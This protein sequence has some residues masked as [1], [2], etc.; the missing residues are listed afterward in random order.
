MP[1]TCSRVNVS[2]ATR[3][4]RSTPVTGLSSPT[5]PTVPAWSRA[6]PAN[7]HKY[8]SAVATSVVNAK[9]AVSFASRA[10][11]AP[12]TTSATAPRI[13]P[14]NTS[15]Q[16]VSATRGV[17]SF[18]RLP[19]T[20]PAEESIRAAA[21]AATPTGSM[22]P[23]AADEQQHPDD[24]GN[25]AGQGLAGH[26]LGHEQPGEA[27][28]RERGER[29]HRSG[30]ARGE[31]L[32]RDVHEQEEGADVERAEHRGAPPPD[33]P[34]ERAGHGEEHETGGQGPERR[35]PHGHVHRQQLARDHVVRAP[36]HGC[37][38]GDGQPFCFHGSIIP[39]KEDI[40]RS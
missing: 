12:S 20:A 5:T 24:A 30:D 17:P 10:G 37:D 19:S 35:A 9:P 39:S 27:G 28:H 3:A 14:P 22:L 34:G 40:F 6:S 26:P 1:A 16:A 25:R 8:A 13:A 29:H 11:G 18:Q 4:P 21:E 23:R 15:C 38:G 7:Q 33:A 36:G 2:W 31:Q 32:C